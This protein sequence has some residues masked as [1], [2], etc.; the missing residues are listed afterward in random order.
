MAKKRVDTWTIHHNPPFEIMDITVVNDPDRPQFVDQ[1][2]WWVKVKT[3]EYRLTVR[4]DFFQMWDVIHE[5]HRK[6]STYMRKLSDSLPLA[7]GEDRAELLYGH[8]KAEGF[9]F[10]LFLTSYIQHRIDLD[11]AFKSQTEMEKRTEPDE[12]YAVMFGNNRELIDPVFGRIPEAIAD[13][14]FLTGVY[15]DVVE[16]AKI[17][18]PDLFRTHPSYTV[19]FER[20]MMK[21]VD[22]LQHDLARL[23]R[24]AERSKKALGL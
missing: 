4:V 18:Y 20:L 9:D 14:S 23:Q 2:Y 7:Q 19:E 1:L 21:S 5:R 6:V 10:A 24:S 16:N 15:E 12:G 3:P 8:M 11:A 22:Q 13:Q 17:C